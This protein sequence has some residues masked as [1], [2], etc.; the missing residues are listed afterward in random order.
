M[1]IFDVFEVSS[2]TSLK[3]GHTQTL[4]GSITLVQNLVFG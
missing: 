4:D 1:S 3:L 2:G